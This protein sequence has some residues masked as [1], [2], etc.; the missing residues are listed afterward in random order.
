MILK[1]LGNSALFPGAPRPIESNFKLFGVL[2]SNSE[3]ST[4]PPCYLPKNSRI[5]EISRNSGAGDSSGAKARFIK[6]DT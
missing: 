2:L 1:K 4:E 5:R 3:N 6:I